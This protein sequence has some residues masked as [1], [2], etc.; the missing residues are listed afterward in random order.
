MNGRH[1]AAALPAQAKQTV[2]ALRQAE[3]GQLYRVH[4]LLGHI[5]WQLGVD[6]DR[7]GVA[8]SRARIGWRT[9]GSDITVVRPDHAVVKALPGTEVDVAPGLDHSIMGLPVDVLGAGG[10]R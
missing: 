2:L 6:V 1:S 9:A 8:T 7:C 3:A 10:V 4:L 5:R